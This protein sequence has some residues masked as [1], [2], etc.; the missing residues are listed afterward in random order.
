MRWPNY[1]TRRFCVKRNDGEL[2]FGSGRLCV[3]HNP[4]GCTIR[5]AQLIQAETSLHF[6]Q[7][8]SFVPLFLSF[9]ITAKRLKMRLKLFVEYLPGK[10]HQSIVKPFINM[11]HLH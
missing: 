7:I 8:T 11:L 1:Q 9:F 4:G 3:S 2:L 10:M 6:R 5:R